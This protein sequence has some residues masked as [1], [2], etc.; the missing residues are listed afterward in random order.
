MNKKIFY[1]KPSI[2]ELEVSY[3]KDAVET[4]WGDS[5]YDY[6]HRF[7]DAF[8]SHLS[9]SYAIAT[10]SATG[11][12]H[13]GL[14]ASGISSGDE[15]ILADTNWIASVSPIVNLGARPVFVDI[16]AD[17]WCLDPSKVEE[18]ITSKTKAI[19][20]VH[21]YGNLCDMDALNSIGLKYSIPVVE[22]SAEAIGSIYNGKKAGTIGSFGTFSFHG[23]KTIT[24][25]EG[26]MF[27]TDDKKIYEKVLTLSNHGRTPGERKQ[28][29]AS[30]IGFK[31]KISNVQAAIGLGQVERIDKLIERK[32]KILKTYKERLSFIEGLSLNPE[33]E[34]GRNGAWM[35]TAVFSKELNI[36]REN[37]LK[38]FK[39]K[40]IDARVFFWPLSS[41]D[42]F[43]DKPE[44]LNS[45][46]IPQRAINLPSYHDMSED[47]IKKVCDVI[48]KLVDRT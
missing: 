32:I 47:E 36:K 2:T 37:L 20:A 25:G 34:S 19:L 28:F 18:A 33:P 41:L 24:T 30:E 40:N 43:K 1:T 27:V 31:Y 7:E 26:G 21:L 22:D 29:W 13:M 9:A 46:D 10:S 14:H 35:P 45:W 11:A 12:L 3:A 6:I 17:T 15:V 42:M 8:K 5:C 16:K 38:N 23:S 4:G 48:I 44:N 39:S